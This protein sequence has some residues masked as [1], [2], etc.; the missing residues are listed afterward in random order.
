[1]TP[2]RRNGGLTPTRVLGVVFHLIVE[3]LNFNLLPALLL[4]AITTWFTMRG[5]RGNE[6]FTDEGAGAGWVT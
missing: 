5:V 4:G 3:N 2:E 6:E 1:L